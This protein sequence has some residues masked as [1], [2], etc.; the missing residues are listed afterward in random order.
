MLFEELFIPLTDFLPREEYNRILLKCGFVIMN[1]LRPQARG[2]IV[3]ALWM[4]ARVFLNKENIM[5]QEFT[6]KGIHVSPLSDIEEQGEEAFVR[7]SDEQVEHNRKIL[8]AQYA[9]KEVLNK[10]RTLVKQ[11]DP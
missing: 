3:T 7:L 6:E 11:L 5:Y 2:N 10:T 1:H 4:G 9:H 8:I